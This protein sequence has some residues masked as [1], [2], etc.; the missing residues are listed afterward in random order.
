MARDRVCLRQDYEALVRVAGYG[1]GR[2]RVGQGRDVKFR[3]W[4]LR[5][6]K[7][8]IRSGRF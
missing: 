6:W 2:G 5:L 7:G 4:K 3:K 1:H 8:G